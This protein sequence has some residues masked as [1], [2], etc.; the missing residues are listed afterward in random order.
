LAIIFLLLLLPELF[1]EKIML[2]LL[3]KILVL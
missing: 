2:L 3:W 1:Q